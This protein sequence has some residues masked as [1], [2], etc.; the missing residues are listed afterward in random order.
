MLDFADLSGYLFLFVG[1][2]I[3]ALYCYTSDMKASARLVGI[4]SLCLGTFGV[5]SSFLGLDGTVYNLA[6]VTWGFSLIG[7]VYVEFRRPKAV[8]I[9]ALPF[10]VVALT[11]F[12][13]LP[14]IVLFATLTLE[15][16]LVDAWRIGKLVVSVLDDELSRMGI[17]LTP[18]T[19]G[20][21]SF[22]RSHRER[23]SRVAYLAN[24]LFPA[25]VSV[26][27]FVFSVLVSQTLAYVLTFIAGFYF[28]IIGFR[29]PST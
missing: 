16:G 5:L 9:L 3:L 6:G 12:L 8:V 10:W 24:S 11:L 21:G 20:F 2:E 1:G 17:L 25:A 23:A 14:W 26:L 7:M 18:F 27:T 22:K 28:V 15:L 13:T 4:S 19:L 29:L